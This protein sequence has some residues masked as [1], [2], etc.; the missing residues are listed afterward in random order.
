MCPICVAARE[1]LYVY[2]HAFDTVAEDRLP[3][4]NLTPCFMRNKKHI[5][6]THP[7][8]CFHVKSSDS[9]A[10]HGASQYETKH[11]EAPCATALS[12]DLT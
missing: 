3:I 6:Y 9:A 1:E 2:C 7:M 5:T 10:A 12:E 8:C 11:C 4:Y